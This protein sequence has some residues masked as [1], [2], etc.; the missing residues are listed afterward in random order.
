M[1]DLPTLRDLAATSNPKL[2]KFFLKDMAFAILKE[3]SFAEPSR[4]KATIILPAA[5]NQNDLTVSKAIQ[6]YENCGNAQNEL[7]RICRMKGVLLPAK[8]S[9]ANADL[10]KLTVVL[11][12]LATTPN[13]VTE[14]N[15]VYDLA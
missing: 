2:Y 10:F 12:F 11:Y 14:I 13:A 3:L 8:I 5:F 15:F 9:E 1:T 7:V 4:K 6:S